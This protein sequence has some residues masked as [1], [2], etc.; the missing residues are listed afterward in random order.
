VVWPAGDPLGRIAADLET[1]RG[2]AFVR[3]VRSGSETRE[4]F[5]ATARREIARELPPPRSAAV[6]AAYAALGLVPP[7][8]DL[9]RGL[10]EALTTQVAA[11]Y[12]PRARVFRVVGSPPVP[13][14]GDGRPA[15]PAEPDPG[16]ALVLAH[17]LVH[18]LQD[19]HFDLVAF[20][21][22]DHARPDL[23][24]D[25]RTARRFLVEGEA[26]FLMMAQGLARGEGKA[27]GLTP[28]AVAGLRMTLRM[29]A[30]ADFL[31]LVSTMRGGGSSAALDEDDRRAMKALAELPPALTVPLV[32]PYFKGA[33][34]VSQAWGQGGWAA[35]DALYR[36]PPAST[37]QALHPGEAGAARARP[38][39]VRAAAGASP[40]PGAALVDSDVLGE[41]GL[42]I[43]FKTWR[44]P[45]GDEA[46]A[47]WG[48]DRYF[49]WRRGGR[50][51]VALA[52]RWDDEDEARA[53][54][55]AYEETLGRRFSGARPVEVGPDARRLR[56]GG[57][58]QTVAR[59][60]LDVDVIGGATAD[61]LP[62][63]EAFLRGLTRA[64]D[65]GAP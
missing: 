59:R 9:A 2:R 20:M 12:D 54:F 51:V 28:L 45:R 63:I 29:L 37:E 17:E 39:R 31:E 15:A 21:D 53:F 19:Q 33:E 35:V 36:A 18:A 24:G 43:Y 64:P 22:D 3:A 32:E 6:S 27:R 65:V 30:A 61:E 42:R 50:T 5:R 13:P 40:W 41:L 48:G 23:D 57:G 26:T 55:T 58:L 46:A 62:A 52:T 56:A 11:Y 7:G 4:A 60:G 16:D 44:H 10:E 1:L 25:G 34:L 14:R 49:A 47:G 38:I 8:F